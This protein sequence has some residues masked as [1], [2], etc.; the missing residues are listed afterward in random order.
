M[1]TNAFF[2]LAMKRAGGMLGKRQRLLLLLSK[3]GMKL[4]TVEWNQVQQDG[5]REKFYAVARLFKAYVQ[6]R[7]TDIPWKSL[8]LIT[9]SIIYFVNPFDLIPDVLFGI[10]FT[11]D[12]AILLMVYNSVQQELEKFMTWERS[13]IGDL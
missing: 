9:A 13:Q 8:L 3:L 6:G 2:D 11:D 1:N 10:G 5:V 7:Y 4:K 12:F